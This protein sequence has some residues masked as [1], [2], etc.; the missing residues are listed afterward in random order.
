MI[1][2]TPLPGYTGDLDRFGLDLK[3]GRLF[4]AAEDQKTV[5]MFDLRSGARIHRISGFGH[6]HTMAYLAPSDQLALTD[7]ESGMVRLV[8]CNAYQIVN[9]IALGHAVDHSA[10]SPSNQSFYVKTDA[11]PSAK[12][13]GLSIIDTKLFRQV[14]TS[15]SSPVIPTRG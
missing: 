14:V 15:L 8:D 1:T 7:S 6:P 13:H 2:T 12:F 4:L 10:L 11:D 9:T 3:G 5:E